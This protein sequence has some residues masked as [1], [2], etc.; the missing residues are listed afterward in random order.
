[1]PAKTAKQRELQRDLNRFFRTYKCWVADKTPYK[2]L[3]D[4]V[5]GPASARAVAMAKRCLGYVGESVNY[6]A[7]PLFRKRLARPLLRR[8]F[9]PRMVARG[10]SFRRAMREAALRPYRQVKAGESY[11]TDS[12]RWKI[13]ATDAP[14][15]V[16]FDGLPVAKWI[17]PG[18]AWDRQHGWHG[19]VINGWRSGA[20][21]QWLWDHASQ[22]G[23]TRGYNVAAPGTSNHEGAVFPRGAVDCNH[24]EELKGLVG[25]APGEH[26]LV[27][28]GPGDL[29]HFS[30]SGR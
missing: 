5:P 4:G 19:H 18:L 21:Q 17:A 6:T 26:K 25:R 3:E 29:V 23:L 13:S 8:I 30:G 28:F 20:H 12:G 9:A 22:L 11:V 14:H 7:D 10:V 16:W 27:W 1:M 15:L 24:H 2:V